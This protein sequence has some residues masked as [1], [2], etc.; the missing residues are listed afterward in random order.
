MRYEVYT[1]IDVTE[2]QARFD[3]ND[4]N[5]HRQQNYMTFLQTVGL[6][7]N[8]VI[9][10]GPKPKRMSVKGLGFG[11][12]YKGQHNVWHFEFDLDFATI[13]YNILVDDFDLVPV[14]IGLDETIKPANSA[15]ETKNPERIN[16]IFKCVD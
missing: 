15:F 5:W 6:R 7:A 16:L 9:E 10:H 14:I 2:T 4:P 12:Q 13:D 3:K 8:P 1:L 11:T